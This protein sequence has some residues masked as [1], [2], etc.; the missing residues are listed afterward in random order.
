MKIYL[1]YL[2]P[3]NSHAAFC[4][5]SP[6][7]S[8]FHR[9]LPCSTGRAVTIFLRLVSPKFVSECL[10]LDGALFPHS[11]SHGFEPGKHIFTNLELFCSLAIYFPPCLPKL[12][13]GRYSSHC[14]STLS[15]ALGC[16]MLPHFLFSFWAEQ[17]VLVFPLPM[18]PGSSMIDSRVPRYLSRLLCYVSAVRDQWSWVRTSL[19]T[20]TRLL[21]RSRST[22]GWLLLC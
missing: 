13:L 6:R 22:C 14:S 12:L 16:R 2:R 1:P 5:V 7:N 11:P 19:L 21:I 15:C 9:I 8:P 3:S 4:K 10:E 17:G 18:R 20:R